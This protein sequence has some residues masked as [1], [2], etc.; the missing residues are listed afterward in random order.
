MK[1]DEK[2]NDELKR[3][4]NTVALVR[5]PGII[6]DYQDIDP[7]RDK[8]T[9]AGVLFAGTSFKISDVNLNAEKFLRLAEN[10]SHNSW[11]SQIKDLT[12]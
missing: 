5:G 10:P 11:C 3:Y 9:Y 4:R 6:V 12:N 2:N 7:G 1:I 8:I